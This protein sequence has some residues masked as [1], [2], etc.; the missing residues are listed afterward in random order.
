MLTATELRAK[1]QSLREQAELQM[2]P[3]AAEAYRLLAQTYDIMAVSREMSADGRKAILLD[4]LD[5][6]L[7]E[8]QG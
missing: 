8:Q 3:G 7:T 4:G 6:G 5:A 1:A 2:D